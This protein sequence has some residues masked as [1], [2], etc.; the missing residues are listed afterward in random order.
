VLTWNIQIND[1]TEGHAR[2]AVDLALAVGPRPQVITFQEAW[3]DF[4][5]AYLDELKKQTGQTWYGVF[6]Q[7]CP[8]GGWNGSTCTK[9]WDQVVAIFSV[10]PIVSTDAIYLPAVDCW[11]S[12]RPGL[13]AGLNVNGTVVQVFTT[14][15]QTGGCNNDMQSRFNSMSRLKTWAANYSKPQIM[16]GDFNADPD[17]IDT[18]SGMRPAFID[19]WSQVGVGR[20][21]SALGGKP[22]MKLDYWFTDAGGRA[23]A[24]STQVVYGTGST[25]DHFPVQT[26][27]TIK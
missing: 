22:T 16:S 9:S 10:Y 8:P 18:T 21:F 20:G 27:F 24:V 17:Q 3:S 2:R 13:R 5:P 25:S 4:F 19:T 1:F 26:T 12:A 14:H 23:R 15:M 11:T 7:L 6:Q